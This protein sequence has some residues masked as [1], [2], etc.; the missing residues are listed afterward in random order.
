MANSRNTIV[1]GLTALV[2]SAGLLPLE[3][4]ARPSKPKIDPINPEVRAV[5]EYVLKNS[6]TLVNT[7]EV[8]AITSENCG[9]RGKYVGCDQSGIRNTYNYKFT[10]NGQEVTVSYQD[11]DSTRI[12]S[13]GKIDSEDCLTVEQRDQRKDFHQS[14]LPF[15][16]FIDIRLDGKYDGYIGVVPLEE[17]GSEENSI[18]QKE[19]E[20]VLKEV[21]EYVSQH[22]LKK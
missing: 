14:V 10:L 11:L 15:T 21:G 3:A 8:Y 13:D 9:R 12:H 22:P 20:S 16:R 6:A 18:I 17:I 4:E 5:V 1:S 7:E 2:L 19:Y